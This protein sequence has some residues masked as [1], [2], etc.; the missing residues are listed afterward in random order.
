LIRYQHILTGYQMPITT[1]EVFIVNHP[2][3]YLPIIYSNCSNLWWGL[4]QIT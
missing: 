3:Y 1:N 4:W 2:F